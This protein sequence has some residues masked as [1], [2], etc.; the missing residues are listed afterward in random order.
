VK[1]AVEPL[2]K[3]DRLLLWS[4]ARHTPPDQDVDHH[5]LHAA[6]ERL[7]FPPQ[8][9]LW[10]LREHPE[11]WNRQMQR[12][13]DRLAG[14]PLTRRQQAQVS[15]ALVTNL[16]TRHPSKARRMRQKGMLI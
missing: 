8:R 1:P 14:V 2:T 5:A 3:K 7:H 15:A 10:I 9:A 4:L 11:A 12:R 13:E 16:K 6:C